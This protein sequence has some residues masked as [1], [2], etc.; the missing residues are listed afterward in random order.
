MLLLY[1]YSFKDTPLASYNQLVQIIM[2]NLLSF[3]TK[4]TFRSSSLFF[5]L[6]LHLSVYSQS[7]WNSTS[8]SFST[9]LNSCFWPRTLWKPVFIP[10]WIMTSELQMQWSHLIFWSVLSSQ[11]TWCCWHLFHLETFPFLGF[12]DHI[13]SSYYSASMT[14][15]STSLAP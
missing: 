10:T 5:K 1:S 8:H 14:T 11:S 9:Q 3:L 13:L 7:S 15:F 6:L 2:L 4:K 12:H